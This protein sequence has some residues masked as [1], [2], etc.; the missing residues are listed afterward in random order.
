[1]SHKSP[2][3]FVVGMPKSG[4]SSIS[5]FFEC[6][7]V[8][9]V[10][11]QMCGEVSC[12]RC[13]WDNIAQ[14]RELLH[15]C[16]YNVYTQ[17]DFD[18]LGRDSFC[19]FPQMNLSLLHKTYP[20]S[21]FILNTRHPIAWVNSVSNWGDLRSR[22]GRCQLG[23]YDFARDSDMIAFYKA[24]NQY[25]RAFAR[26]TGHTLIEVDIEH[27][28]SALVKSTRI[29]ESCFKDANSQ[30]HRIRQKTCFVGD[31]LVRYV[32]C[33]HE[34]RSTECNKWHENRF[35]KRSNFFWKPTVKEILNGAYAG[36]DIIV[37]NNLFHEVR[38]NSS[39]FKSQHVRAKALKAVDDK[40][41]S[42]AKRVI[43]YVSQEPIGMFSRE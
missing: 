13:I 27:N 38:S 28:I 8:K 22:M 33:W 6:G 39:I 23:P 41:S 1:M 10:T 24:H 26:F 15:G 9:G 17:L 21:T 34:T 19:F 4:T 29:K 31:S 3:Y 12:A 43:F 40:L 30:P 35:G 2:T 20:S 11:H 36:C 25:V 42:T 5:N 16:K 37:W 7:G 14:K 32:W 18:G